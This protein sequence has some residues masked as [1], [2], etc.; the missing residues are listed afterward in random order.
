MT[1]NLFIVCP[2]SSVEIRLKRKYGSNAYF[3]SCPGAIIPYS[4]NI[5]IDIL[6]GEIIR[7]NINSVYF[8]NDTSSIINNAVLS[9]KD[10]FG[11]DSEGLVK[12][13]YKNIFPISLK[14]RSMQYQQFRLAELIVQNQKD[15]FLTNGVFT[16]LLIDEKIMVKTLVVSHSMNFFKESRIALPASLTYEL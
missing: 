15:E 2:F 6:K 1:N 4:D 3:I 12:N 13:I 7:N 9:N 10:L 11:L 14:G 5:F 8:V 16:D